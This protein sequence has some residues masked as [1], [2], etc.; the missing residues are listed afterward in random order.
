VNSPISYI[1][2]FPPVP[3]GEPPRV[4]GTISHTPVPTAVTPM[5]MYQTGP[6]QGPQSLFDTLDRNHDGVLSRSEFAQGMDQQLLPAPMMQ[7]QQ[8]GPELDLYTITPQGINIH[9]LHH[10]APPAG[11]P[12]VATAMLPSGVPIHYDNP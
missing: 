10:Q 9:H 3:T 11:V 4:V 5:P 6:A 7:Q 12:V 2:R 1:Q 8:Q